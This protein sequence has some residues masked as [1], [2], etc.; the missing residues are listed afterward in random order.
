MCRQKNLSEN[1]EHILLLLRF[2]HAYGVHIHSKEYRWLDIGFRRGGRFASM[3]PRR[4]YHVSLKE[5]TALRKVEFGSNVLL[6]FRKKHSEL[7]HHKRYSCRREL[8][9]AFVNNEGSTNWLLKQKRKVIAPKKVISLP[10][11][12]AP[13][14]CKQENQVESFVNQVKVSLSCYR[15]ITDEVTTVD[16][17]C[18][19]CILLGHHESVHT[20]MIAVYYRCMTPECLAPVYERRK[21]C[22]HAYETRSYRSMLKSSHEGVTQM[23]AF[24]SPHAGDHSTTHVKVIASGVPLKTLCHHHHRHHHHMGGGYHSELHVKVIACG[25]TTQNSISK[26][27]HVV[28]PPNLTSKSSHVGVPPKCPCQNDCMEGVPPKL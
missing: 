13:K 11:A 26:S 23:A 18:L 10:E 3:K 17:C 27:S 22:T 2:Q 7:K 24:K 9:R 20:N 21:A 6:L 1:E 25:G 4:R 15:Y 19:I 16:R 5:G 8:I 14:H 28:V 12:T